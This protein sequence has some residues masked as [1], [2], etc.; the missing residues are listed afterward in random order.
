[1]NATIRSIM[2]RDRFPSKISLVAVAVFI[3]LSGCSSQPTSTIKVSSDGAFD[4]DR[5]FRAKFVEDDD[6]DGVWDSFGEER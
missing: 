4:R 2:K 6:L 1:M 5:K 3:F